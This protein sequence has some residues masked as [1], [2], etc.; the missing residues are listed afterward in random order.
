MQRDGALSLPLAQVDA[1]KEAT[2]AA[3]ELLADSVLKPKFLPWE[4]EEERGALKM[5]LDEAANNPQELL[6]EL[7][8]AAAF[9]SRT[10]LGKPLPC[11]ARNLPL[12]TPEVL[13]AFVETQVQGWARWPHRDSAR[14]GD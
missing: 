5:E 13:S 8:N 11:P 3:V 2:P 14:R 7:S 6:T 9:G 1:L 12:I 4:L 10:P